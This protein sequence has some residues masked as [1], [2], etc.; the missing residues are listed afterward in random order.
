MHLRNR[1]MDWVRAGS[2]G[3]I[4]SALVSTAAIGVEGASRES[5][6]HAEMLRNRALTWHLCDDYCYLS[7]H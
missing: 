4:L 7:D 1:V 5:L 6:A 3:L 2:V